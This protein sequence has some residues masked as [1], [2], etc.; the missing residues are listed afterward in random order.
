MLIEH[1]RYGTGNNETLSW[2]EQM[3]QAMTDIH[4]MKLE[5]LKQVLG[6]LNTILVKFS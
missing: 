5:E 3:L 4:C 2:A 6:D 1:L